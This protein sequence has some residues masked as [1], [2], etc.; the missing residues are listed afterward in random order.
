MEKLIEYLKELG[1]SSC[2]LVSGPNGRFV[3]YTVNGK[4]STLPV[5]KKSQNGTLAEFNVLITDDGQPIAT[6][7]HYEDVEQMELA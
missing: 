1:A 5:G 6:V 2:R 7:N 3:S 4:Q